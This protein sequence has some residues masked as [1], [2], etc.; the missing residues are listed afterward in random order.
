MDAGPSFSNSRTI[1]RSTGRNASKVGS[2]GPGMS[3]ITRA[4]LSFTFCPSGTSAHLLGRGR[5]E[6]TS[7]IGHG[8]CQ[9][10]SGGEGNTRNTSAPE[11]D[12]ADAVVDEVENLGAVVAELVD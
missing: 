1:L 7:M 3:T 9:L 6:G 4:F 11:A 8:V 10:G 5:G 12:D 2:P